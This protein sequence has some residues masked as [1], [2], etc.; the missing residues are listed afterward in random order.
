MF[1]LSQYPTISYLKCIFDRALRLKVPKVCTPGMSYKK[2]F[3]RNEFV[4][5]FNSIKIK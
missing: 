3:I 5:S 4:T 1:S 2:R